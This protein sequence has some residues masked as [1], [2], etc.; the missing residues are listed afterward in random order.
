MKI[1]TLRCFLV[2]LG[3]AVASAT[4]GQSAPKAEL[5]LNYEELFVNW[6]VEPQFPGGPKALATFIL[7]HQ[8]YPED[9]RQYN[10]RG[11]VY[12]SFV[13]DEHGQISDVVILKGLGFGCDEEA[14][15]IIRKMPRWKPGTTHNKPWRVKYQ[16]PF[17]FPPADGVYPGRPLRPQKTL[18]T[19]L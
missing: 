4:F 6:E 12:T 17:F 19:T 3:C 18:S 8:R 5:P 11:R 7:K 14:I 1:R 15:R 9:A 16:L 2:L 13:I 10:V